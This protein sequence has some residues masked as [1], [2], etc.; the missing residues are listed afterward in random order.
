VIG[1]HFF[2]PMPVLLLV[3]VVPSVPTSAEVEATVRGLAEGL[4]GSR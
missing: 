2:N 4:P 3:E 1:M